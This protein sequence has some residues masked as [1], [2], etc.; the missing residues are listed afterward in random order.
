M[1]FLWSTQMCTIKIR[2]NVCNPMGICDFFAIKLLIASILIHHKWCWIKPNKNH[3]ISVDH[4]GLAIE[5]SMIFFKRSRIEAQKIDYI[6]VVSWYPRN[7][8]HYI[9][10][11]RAPPMLC[12]ALN[13]IFYFLFV[14][15]C[16]YVH[17]KWHLRFFFASS[18]CLMHKKRI[19][20]F[21][22][23][24]QIAMMHVT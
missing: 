20:S 4:L 21:D 8:K 15:S 19:N 10:S 18:V 24:F 2:I 23:G 13:R 5:P 14:Y 16:L 3:W 9:L 22:Y 7:R 1:P 12:N 11:I 6:V 17:I